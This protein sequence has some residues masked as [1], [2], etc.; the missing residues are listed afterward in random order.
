MANRTIIW[1]FNGTLLDDMD[2][3][4]ASVNDMLSRRGGAPMDR[5]RYYSLVETPIIRFYQ[6]VDQLKDV[7][8]DIITQ[9]FNA[10]YEKHAELIRL[11]DG[12]AQLLADFHGKGIRQV[13]VSAF[14]Q[15]HIEKWLAA[16]SV[17]GYFEAVLG[18]GDMLAES[19]VARARA[20]ADRSGVNR[21]NAVFVGDTTHDWETA[22]AMDVP[23]VLVSYGHQARRDLEA[24]G[25]P[26][27]DRLA[28]LPGLLGDKWQQGGAM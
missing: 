14:E 15:S 7:P 8:F 13:I 2:A 28:E 11:A 23:C 21:H 24:C 18:A 19:K 10:G 26:V 22:R 25:V 16:F 4:L 6:R 20:W 27:I 3:A 1:D 9:E 17:T 12:A 5:A